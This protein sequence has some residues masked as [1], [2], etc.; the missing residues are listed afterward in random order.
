MSNNTNPAHPGPFVRSKLPAD[1]AVKEAAKRLGVGRPAL[2]N[3]LNAK[4]SLSRE[5]A[6][7]L[8][9]TFKLDADG[10]LQMQAAYDAACGSAEIGK[11][12][13]GS[14]YVPAVLS[15]RADQI[16]AWVDRTPLAARSGTR[17]SAAHP[18]ELDRSRPQARGLS[19]IRKCRASRLG[20][21]GGGRRCNSWVPAGTSGWE[22]G[23]NKDIDAKANDDFAK[24]TSATPDAERRTTTFVFVTPRN[25][26]KK[27][28]WEKQKRQVS[29]WQDVRAFDAS[30]IEQWIE[31]SVS[32]QVWFAER[33]GFPRTGLRTLDDC[34]KAWSEATEPPLARELLMPALPSSRDT[35]KSWLASPPS[36][37]LVISADSR[38]EALAFIDCLFR[39]TGA[40]VLRAGDDVI[41]VDTA[42]AARKLASASPGS[43]VMVATSL[44]VERE[45][46]TAHKSF[47][48][49]VVRPRN[50]VDTDPDIGLDLLSHSEFKAALEKMGLDEERVERLGRESGRSPTILRRRLA[51]SAAIK[52]PEWA[53]DTSAGTKAR[54]GDP[55]RRMARRLERG[56]RDR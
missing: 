1:L 47:H 7:R 6:G 25:W 3:F 42:D 41:V 11:A 16:E 14:V 8:A 39:D 34:G 36:K 21:Y 19:S 45:L 20:R 51:V 52:S 12:V 17:R 30:D 15:I 28:A 44:E 49:I 50:A 33:N 32:G 38:S 35:L 26:P 10:L 48:C 23:C 56:C 40:T 24:R 55:G 46:G 43:M 9:A 18:G 27:S 22:F 31:Q 37:P 5:M 13:V 54:G 4:A 2:S 53:R 29:N